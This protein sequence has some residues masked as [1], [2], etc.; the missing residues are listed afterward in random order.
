MSQ[1]TCG[2]ALSV[3]DRFC[4]SCGQENLGDAQSQTNNEEIR[5]IITDVKKKE[6]MLKYRAIFLIPTSKRLI[7]FM[8]TRSIEKEAM[9]MFAKSLE[10]QGFKDRLKANLSPSNRMMAFFKD[11]SV[12]EI[13]AMNPESYS[14]D[15]DDIT[16]IKFPGMVAIGSKKNLYKLK[17]ETTSTTHEVYFDPQRNVIP[18]AKSILKSIIPEKVS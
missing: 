7:F 17:I 9:D 1:C 14:V 12:E 11:K 4:P 6:S 13:L 16:R 18:E 2:S 5:G 10:G 3:N 15:L 8:T